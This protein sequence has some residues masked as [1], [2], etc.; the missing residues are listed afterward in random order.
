MTKFE[1]KLT[2]LLNHLDGKRKTSDAVYS[3]VYQYGYE[4]V[5]A[6]LGMYQELKDQD[7]A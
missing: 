7:D 1:A 6:I 4:L 5:R 3:I 2:R